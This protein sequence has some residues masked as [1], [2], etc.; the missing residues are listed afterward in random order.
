MAG[1]TDGILLLSFT[2]SLPLHRE[3]T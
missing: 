1:L 2:R 3:L